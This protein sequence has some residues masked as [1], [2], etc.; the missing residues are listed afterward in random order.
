VTRLLAYDG[1]CVSCSA[2]A[3]DP[4]A[5]VGSDLELGSLSDPEIKSVLDATRPGW[6]HQ[7]MLIE[8]S[9]SGQVRVRAGLSMT[10]SMARLLGLRRSVGVIRRLSTQYAGP[11]ADGADSL[12][13]S[14]RVA[15]RGGALGVLGLLTGYRLLSPASA[16]AAPVT[17]SA[18]VT[19]VQLLQSNAAIR[20]AS[21][22]YGAPDWSAVVYSSASPACSDASPAYVLTHADGTFTAVTADLTDA[23]SYRVGGQSGTTGVEWLTAQGAPFALSTFGADGAMTSTPAPSVTP[24]VSEAFYN[25]FTSCLLLCVT[26][27]CAFNCGSCIVSPGISNCGYCTACAGTAGVNCARNCKSLW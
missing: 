4:Q 5:L 20:N 13:V 25:C 9:R 17:R 12:V 26:S 2:I 7:P 19:E 21:A 24:D 3:R 10:L 23:L 6:R 11:T 15:L 18:S 16:S 22:I 1:G 8:T 27:T 14:R